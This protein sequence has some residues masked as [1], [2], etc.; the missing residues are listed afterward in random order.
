VSMLTR[1][2]DRRCR[3]YEANGYTI[4]LPASAIPGWPADVQLPSDPVSKREYSGSVGR[5]V[6]DGIDAPLAT[7]NP[8]LAALQRELR[9]G[10]SAVIATHPRRSSGDRHSQRK[11]LPH[12]VWPV[13]LK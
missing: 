7:L 9:H 13:A 5:L 12:P 4:L 11:S 6:R 3:G 1:M 8:T 10:S 2:F